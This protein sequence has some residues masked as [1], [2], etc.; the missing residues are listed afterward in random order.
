MTNAK[1]GLNTAS[2][3][4]GFFIA[5]MLV[6]PLASFLIFYVYMNLNS[7][8]MAFTSIDIYGK[9]TFVGFDNFKFFLNSLKGDSQVG[10]SLK[11][12]ITMWILSFGISMP[13]YLIFSYFIYK[14]MIGNK[15]FYILS[16]IPQIVSTFVFA[17][18]YKRFVE[19]ALPDIMGALGYDD[20]PQL[21]YDERYALGNNLFFSI[22]LSFGT[23][24]MVYSNAMT[25]VSVD[26]IESAHIDGVNDVEEF[27]SIILPMIWPTLS[28][29]VITGVVSFFTWSGSLLTFYMYDAPP[30][31]WGFGYYI[32]RT[33]K[34]AT[35]YMG[36]PLVAT[37][38]LCV[39]V[40]T[41]P[42]VFL[43]KFIMD[44]LDRTN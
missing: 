37:S 30:A 31:I 10:L 17:L 12:S 22:W 38:G 1:K 15:M 34:T 32:T 41:A 7:F 39:T 4:R 23:S 24:V 16:M 14:K 27:F 5:A 43:V 11:N 13:L 29:Y 8:G 21:I 6:V 36:Y 40:I 18:V 28:T 3:K 42:L 2:V 33:V 20:F 9:S 26:I 25:A 19:S 35:D 44:K